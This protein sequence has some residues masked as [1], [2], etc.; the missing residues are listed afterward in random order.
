MAVF[1]ICL[2]DCVKSFITSLP[3]NG[4]MTYCFFLPHEMINYDATSRI[5]FISIFYTDRKTIFSCVMFHG[6]LNFGASYL[7]NGLVDFGD[8]YII[9]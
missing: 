6:N 1:P 9:L 7:E 5:L 8:T 3:N 2:T 4:D